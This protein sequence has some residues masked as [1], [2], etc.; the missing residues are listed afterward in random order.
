[1]PDTGTLSSQ[2][3]RILLPRFDT[4]GDIVLLEGF[5]EALLRRFP[6]AKVTLLIRRV[7][8]DL[9]CLFPC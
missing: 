2:P 4:I 7:Y 5:L 8:A 6:E 9:A 3:E 1:M